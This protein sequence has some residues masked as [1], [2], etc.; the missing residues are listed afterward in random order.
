[1]PPLLL[2]GGINLATPILKLGKKEYKPKKPKLKLWRQIV[3]LNERGADLANE[4]AY[5]DMLAVVCLAYD[6]PGVTPEALEEHLDIDEFL[7][8]FNKLTEWVGNILAGK[9]E[10]LPNATTP[11]DA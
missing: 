11:A 9:L 2:T 7:P 3:R 6:N 5:D 10:Q 8:H 4:A 1:M